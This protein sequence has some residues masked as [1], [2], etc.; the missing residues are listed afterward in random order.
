MLTDLKYAVR[1]LVRSPGFTLVALVTLA[2]GIGVNTAMFTLLNAIALRESPAYDSDRLV[3]I[4]RSSPQSQTWPHSPGDFRDM[5]KQNKSFLGVAG[6]TWGN[7][8]LAEPGQ[9]AER[10]PAMTVSAEFFQLFGIS[11]ELGRYAGPDDDRP[12]VGKVAVISDGFWHSHFGADPGIIGRTVRLDGQPAMIVGV[13]P[14]RFDNPLYWGRVDIWTPLAYDASVW[15]IRNDHWLQAF[16]RL[17]PGVSLSQAQAEASMIGSQLARDHPDTDAQDGLHLVPWNQ[18]RVSDLSRR[19]SWLC[20]GLSAFVLLIACANLANLQLARTSDKLQEHAMRIALGASRLRLIRQFLVESTLLSL[21]GGAMG[22]LVASWATRLIGSGIMIGDIPGLDL[23]VDTRVLAFSL[24]AALLTGAVFGT[25]PAWIASHTD[26]NSTIKQGGR[27]GTGGRSRHR[28]RQALIVSELVL[29]LVLMSGAGYFVRGMQRVARN[30]MGWR[31]E[32]LVTAGLTLPFNASY[33]TDEQC[34][35]F[36]EKLEAKLAELPGVQSA[37]VSATLPITG[38]W[39]S[40]NFA[41]EGREA[42]PRGKEPLAYYNPVTPG[43]FPTLGIRLLRGRGFSAEDRAGAARVVIINEAMAKKLWP[44]EDPIGKRIGDVNPAN[45][46]WRQ[47]VGVVSDIR[48]FI[49]IVRPADTPFQVYRPLAQAPS[50]VAHYLNIAVRGTAPFSTLGPAL[51]R[52]V[53]AI[54][55]DQPVY[56]MSTA[57]EAIQNFTSSFT[58]IS[59]LLSVF[60]ALGLVLSAVGL[61]GVVA[62]LVAQRIP[63][64]GIRM[65]LGAQVRDVL[66]MVLRQGMILAL[67]GAGIGLAFAWGLI[68]VLKALLPAIPGSDPLA[69]ACVT[70]TLVLVALL[71]C[72]LPARRAASVDPISALRSE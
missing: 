15:K 64:I 9:P 59:Q 39:Q 13:M 7:V 62:N 11:P 2:L 43:F 38:F 30:D 21:L 68:R 4:F 63:E 17:K 58:L 48:A 14:A 3:S 34:R 66:W 54:D 35:A 57:T 41:V 53:E 18:V 51:R 70:A 71:A 45:H 42:P 1:Q 23:P 37:S 29:A 12:G 65:A 50:H 49:E 67:T 56:S 52:T 55:P 72:W 25:V 69:L 8:N 26:V 6:Y 19:I 16:G 31:P 47:V 10:L 60:A 40:D 22:V 5:Q 32:G 20:M 36:D 28:L 44:G 24:A 33:S 61:Y 46:D 27:G